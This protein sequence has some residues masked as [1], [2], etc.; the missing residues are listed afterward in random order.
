M[1]IQCTQYV[2]GQE[3]L[4]LSFSVIDDLDGT[5]SVKS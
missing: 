5:N 3:S 4:N 1:C 2:C